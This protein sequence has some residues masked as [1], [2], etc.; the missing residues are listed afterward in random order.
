VEVE[1]LL[2]DMVEVLLVDFKVEMEVALPFNFKVDFME[3]STVRTWLSLF[4][5]YFKRCP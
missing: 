4:Y 2:M 1:D 5:G 3:D